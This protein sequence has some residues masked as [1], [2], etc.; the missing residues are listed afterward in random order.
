VISCGC[1]DVVFVEL[2]LA[3]CGRIVTVHHHVFSLFI[4]GFAN[5][6]TDTFDI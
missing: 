1:L 3:E 6:H 5:M 4:T 2:R